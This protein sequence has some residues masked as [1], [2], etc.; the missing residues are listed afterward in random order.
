MKNNVCF[1]VETIYLPDSL[2]EKFEVV[3]CDAEQVNLRWVEYDND[4][5]LSCAIN[6][7]AGSH[8]NLRLEDDDTFEVEAE[9]V[10][11]EFASDVDTE[12]PD[13]EML[14]KITYKMCQGEYAVRCIGRCYV[15]LEF[16]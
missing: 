14:D 3:S 15:E 4:A 1:K 2:R 16:I 5:L 13:F 11:N 12:D 6:P 10:F 9:L 7:I 8:L